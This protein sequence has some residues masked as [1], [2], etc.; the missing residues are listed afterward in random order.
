MINKVNNCVNVY[1]KIV[2]VATTAI[3]IFSFIIIKSNCDINYVFFVIICLIVSILTLYWGV[4]S[5]FRVIEGHISAIG[6]T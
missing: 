5:V 2:L 3:P 6:Y 4:L 1:L